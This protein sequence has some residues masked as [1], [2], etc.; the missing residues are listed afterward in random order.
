MKKK[1]QRCLF[2][3]RLF[4][5]ETSEISPGIPGAPPTTKS[6]CPLCEAR[7]RKEAENSQ[8]EPKPM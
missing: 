2:C 3:A 7:L 1:Q 4:E 6:I 8:K 5:I